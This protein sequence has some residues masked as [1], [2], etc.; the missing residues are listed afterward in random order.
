MFFQAGIGGI[1]EKTLFVPITEGPFIYAG[2]CGKGSET[3]GVIGQGG[4]GDEESAST[5]LAE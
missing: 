4:C 3:G 2:I 1:F 5:I